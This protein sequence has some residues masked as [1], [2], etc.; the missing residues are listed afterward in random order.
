MFKTSKNLIQ[1][2]GAA[3]LYISTK[4]IIMLNVMELTLAAME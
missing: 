1:C 3:K 2:A 4:A